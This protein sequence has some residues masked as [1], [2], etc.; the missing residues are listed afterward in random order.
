M[1]RAQRREHRG[2]YLLD[3]GS[4]NIPD[5]EELTIK[6][7]KM[8]KSGGFIT[9]CKEGDET[10]FISKHTNDRDSKAN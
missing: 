4:V 6:G 9:D 2:R 10:V 1:N 8:L 7:I 3:T 5:G